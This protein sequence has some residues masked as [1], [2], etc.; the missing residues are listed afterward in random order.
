MDLTPFA[1]WD[2][3]SDV[4]ERLAA[5]NI[6][7][8]TEVQQQCWEPILSGRDVLVQSNTGT[9]KTLACALPLWRHCPA[10]K[11]AVDILVVL[12]T[13]ELA[14]Q[15]AS[16]WQGLGANVALLYGGGGYGEQLGAL[17]AGVRV[18]VGTPGRIGDH[19]NR[20]SLDLGA[21]RV[22]VLD[23]ADEMLDMGF[24]EE[25][26]AILAKMPAQYQT[27]LFSA[28]LR[29]NIETLAA[30]ILS[31]PLRIS[32]SSGLA[33]APD[34]RH[35]AYEVDSDYKHDAL[36]NIL[37]VESPQSALIFCHTKAEADELSERL[38]G[39]GIFCAC[40]HGDMSQAERTRTLNNF[41]RGYVRFLVA[42]DVAA[43]GIDVRGI[44]HVINI[45]VPR[46]TE[47]Y[48]HRVGRTGR[49]GENGTAITLVSPRD[50]SRFIKLLKAAHI[51]VEVR[52]LPQKADV[53]IMVRQSFHSELCQRVEKGADPAYRVLAKELLDYIEPEDIVAV[54]LS[55][56][57]KA[58]ACIKA[59][60][61]IPV[62]KRKRVLGGGEEDLSQGALK[63]QRQGDKACNLAKLGKAY[64][65]VNIGRSDGIDEEKLLQLLVAV[66]G[67]K[68]LY[69]GKIEL[70][71]RT[72]FFETGLED[73]ENIATQLEGLEWENHSLK[74]R[75]IKPSDVIGTE[76]GTADR[77]ASN[78]KRSNRPFKAQGRKRCSERD[79][80]NSRYQR[81]S[82]KNERSA[83]QR[84]SV[85]GKRPA[86]ERKSEKNRGRQR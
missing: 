45:S 86:G 59:G 81:A 9:G 61:N 75:V 5:Q 35:L 65:Q 37:Q 33:V 1:E 54:L 38:R 6:T 67:K 42:T 16:A 79:K 31:D 58:T 24:A 39:D 11:G 27:L 53:R 62:P 10:G 82:K 55:Q 40:L 80:N 48:I 44:T 83:G 7:V 73:A 47:T 50:F 56:M 64:L 69:F 23:E 20:G 13:R 72:A 76:Y 74:V 14:M 28:T 63:R 36:C 34:I 46:E 84:S 4:L 12:P 49:A 19:L 41:R 68:R 15:V 29:D 2:L 18:V 85:K 32:V 26:E 21:C 22:L 25:I 17:K 30:K 3:T 78:K 70:R 8:P 60:F 57:S 51:K 66:T 52:P 71:R 77:F 43:R